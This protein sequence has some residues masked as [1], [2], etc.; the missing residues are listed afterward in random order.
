MKENGRH[1]LGL[2]KKESLMSMGHTHTPDPQRL[3]P[4]TGGENLGEAAIS[5][6]V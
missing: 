6:R 2:M 4:E 3:G 5:T 1:L